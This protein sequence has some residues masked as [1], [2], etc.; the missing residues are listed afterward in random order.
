MGEVVNS[1]V[2]ISTP[3]KELLERSAIL[4]WLGTITSAA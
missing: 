4:L 1:R 3:L 2:I